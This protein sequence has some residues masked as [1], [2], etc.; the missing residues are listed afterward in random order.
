MKVGSGTPPVLTPAGWMTIYHGVE[1]TGPVGVYR[2]FWALM[3]RDDP[4]RLLTVHDDTP[5]LEAD[6]ALLAPI[7]HQMY[8]PSPVVFTTGIVDGGDHWIVASGEGD[9]ACRMSW[10]DKGRFL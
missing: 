3:D 8:L 4:A 1:K 6:P 5:L 9:L 2:S 10:I 7:A